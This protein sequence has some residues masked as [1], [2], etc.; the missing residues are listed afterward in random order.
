MQPFQGSGIYIYIYIYLPTCQVRVLR[1]YVSCLLL[2]LFLL[3]L[4]P[5]PQRAAT[6]SVPC[7][8][9][10]PSVYCRTSTSEHMSERMSEN[11]PAAPACL[12]KVG[13]DDGLLVCTSL[14]LLLWPKLNLIISYGARFYF[15]L[16]TPLPTPTTT[17]TTPYP[18]GLG[19]D[20][21]WVLS[22]AAVLVGCWLPAAAVAAVA[23]A[24]VAGV[25][26]VVVAVAVAFAFGGASRH[27]AGNG[28]SA[29][30]ARAIEWCCCCCC[31]FWWHF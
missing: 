9:S 26:A 29:S 31:C 15:A 8:A 22:S 19:L 17:K 14:L 3:F 6:S 21:P 13:L 4:L 11:P 12:L 27:A 7:R 23:A 16:K 28:I 1:F 20:S 25:V 5:R 30:G 10:V 2:L 18:K 24:L